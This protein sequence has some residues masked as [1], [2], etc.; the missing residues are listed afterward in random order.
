MKIINIIYIIILVG[1]ISSCTK[2]FNDINTDP[3]GVPQEEASAK[4]FI[5]NPQYNLYAPGRYYYWRAHIIHADRFAGYFTFG[6]KGCW[7][8]DAL[9][10]QYAA[11]YTD[12]AWDWLA[13]HL[14]QLNNFLKLTKE[15]GE[16][17]NKY[18]YATGLIMKGLYFQMY[19]DVF[20][21]IPYSEAGKDDVTLP[22]YDTQKTI[23]K[24]I[25]ADLNNAIDI[26]GNAERSGAGIND[27]G[28][29]DLYCGGDMQKWRKLANTLILRIALR[30]N[31]AP[32]DDFS[33]QAIQKAMGRK[34]FLETEADNVLIKKDNKIDRWASAGYS[35]VWHDFGGKGSKW[36]VSEVLINYLQDY[37]DPRMIKYAQPAEGSNDTIEFVQPSVTKEDSEPHD[38]FFERV[39]HIRDKLAKVIGN[40]DF[41]NK[42]NDTVV[43]FVIPKSKYFIGQPIRFS[44]GIYKYAKWEFFSI[45]ANPIIQKKNQDEPI[46]SELVMTTAESY[47][48]RAEAA[49]KGLSSENAQELFEKGI[50][51]AM[52]LW[53]VD[54]ASIKAYQ[55]SSDLA[56]LTGTTEEKIEKISIQ[57]WLALY[58]DG[59]EG[60]SVVRKS[61]YPKEIS[62]DVEND[63]IYFIGGDIGN[64][65][66]QRMRYGSGAYATNGTN[67]NAAVGR[68]GADLQTTKLWWAKK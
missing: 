56:K 37:N 63:H 48:L 27:L 31:G 55:S 33:E 32:G 18:M 30:A 6:F 14:G 53:N 57:R 50:E 36:H 29:N 66:P 3:N 43:A 20:G 17:E 51:Y 24:G 45:P 46:F 47:F 7:W 68:Q 59:F 64:K 5:T 42:L 21:E 23:Y 67:V 16:F 9:S 58:T 39:E 15:G 25:I 62:K 40:T 34:L 41:Y 11:G 61:G 13:K 52:T 8:Y 19:T 12:A 26:I 49:V 44:G 2:D 38:Y 54:G 10:Y 28:T 60:W 4:F 1:L 22:K 35:D 65:Y